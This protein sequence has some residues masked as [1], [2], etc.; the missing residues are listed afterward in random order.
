MEHHL[1]GGDALVDAVAGEDEEVGVVFGGVVADGTQGVGGR[2]TADSGGL[3]VG[4]VMVGDLG[5]A[6]HA[7]LVGGGERGG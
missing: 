5:E 7:D 4:K 1:L 3:A 6:E 2:V